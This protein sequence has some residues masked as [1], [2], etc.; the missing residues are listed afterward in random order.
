MAEYNQLRKA[1]TERFMA[2]VQPG[3]GLGLAVFS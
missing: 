2:V 1:S 3:A